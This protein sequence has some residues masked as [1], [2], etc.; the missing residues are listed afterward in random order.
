MFRRQPIVHRDHLEAAFGGEQAAQPVMAFQPADNK[1]AAME[2]DQ[3]GLQPH[4]GDGCI[5]AGANVAAGTGNG[6]IVDLADRD[7]LGRGQL[8]HAG[9]GL[10]RHG[11]RHVPGFRARDRGRLVEKGFHQRVERHGDP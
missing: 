7:I 2:I 10:A 11:G 4:R 1:A 3:C 8:H 5:G 9:K 6:E